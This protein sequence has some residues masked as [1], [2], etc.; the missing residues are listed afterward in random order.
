VAD[1]PE[2]PAGFARVLPVST[3]DGF[4]R[5]SAARLRFAESGALASELDD[6]CGLQEAFDDG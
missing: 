6:L 2:V 4:E 1:V 3:W 5:A